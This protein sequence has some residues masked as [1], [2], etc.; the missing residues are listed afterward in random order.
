MLARQTAHLELC[1]PRQV[2]PF[3]QLLRHDRQLSRAIEVLSAAETPAELLSAE[4]RALI[5][6]ALEASEGNQLRAASR[7]GISRQGLINKIR[8][9]GVRA[10][11]RSRSRPRPGR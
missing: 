10:S 3:Q 7:L 4:E 2:G 9:Y 8:R 5:E 11:E 1:H 6:E